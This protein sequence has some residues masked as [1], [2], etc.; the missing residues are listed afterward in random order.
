MGTT[1]ERRRSWKPAG[2]G[3]VVLVSG[4]AYIPSPWEGFFYLLVT[5]AAWG[6]GTLVRQMQERSRELQVLAGRV[7][8]LRQGLAQ[9][10]ERR[11]VDVDVRAV[12]AHVGGEVVGCFDHRLSFQDRLESLTLSVSRSMHRSV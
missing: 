4:F 2:F 9:R 8:Q 12:H 6:V 5:G 11:R 10:V 3:F 1:F 7:A